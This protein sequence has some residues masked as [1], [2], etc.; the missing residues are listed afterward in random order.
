[1]RKIY[2]FVHGFGIL[3]SIA[4]IFASNFLSYFGLS[5]PEK[6]DPTLFGL[7]VSIIIYLG[8]S[9]FGQLI[10]FIQKT[11]ESESAVISK[12]TNETTTLTSNFEDRFN[13]LT[14]IFEDKTNE[15]R[16]RF[17]RLEEYLENVAEK[18]IVPEILISMDEHE[19]VRHRE[20]FNKSLSYGQREVKNAIRRDLINRHSLRKVHLEYNDWTH[21]YDFSVIHSILY[22]HAFSG[23]Y[24]GSE[25]NVVLDYTVSWNA[26]RV[27]GEYSF[28]NYFRK[29]ISDRDKEKH[30]T[31]RIHFLIFVDF[32]G[33]ESDSSNLFSARAAAVQLEH[34]LK[35]VL[36]LYASRYF[37]D[38][39]VK[40]ISPQEIYEEAS[41]TKHFF[42]I[43][44]LTLHPFKEIPGL[45]KQLV[46]QPFNVYAEKCVSR[47]VVR[48]LE[49]EP[50]I[51][52]L[53]VN[54]NPVMIREY[55]NCFNLMWERAA[56]ISGQIFEKEDDWAD[57]GKGEFVLR[58]SNLKRVQ[59]GRTV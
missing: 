37:T 21:I 58:W 23:S 27:F 17:D 30:C 45:S 34:S 25:S 41:N 33:F 26:D 1:M 44:I 54:V 40:D 9:R 18:R 19:N 11:D 20:E 49:S 24:R 14:L 8:T 16:D 50:P 4:S 7:A 53:E 15:L 28:E 12:I 55:T 47:S 22:R 10:E 46:D 31:T 52:H 6:V 39:N 2:I 59:K 42:T 35:D 48:H 51:P 32:D 38:R 43:R 56:T 5:L 36:S 57:F 13:E 29:V 3:L